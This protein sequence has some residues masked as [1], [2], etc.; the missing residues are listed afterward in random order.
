MFAYGHGEPCPYKN[1]YTI[2]VNGTSGK[3]SPTER[4]VVLYNY[5]FIGKV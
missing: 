5:G 3:P 4:F 1:C 2:F